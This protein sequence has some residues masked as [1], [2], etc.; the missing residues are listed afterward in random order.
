ME[1]LMNQRLLVS[2]VWGTLLVG[3]GGGSMA[4]MQTP[5]QP[6]APTEADI[7]ASPAA[8][9][10][11]EAVA[12]VGR[13]EEAVRALAEWCKRQNIAPRFETPKVGGTQVL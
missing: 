13:D 8:K 11:Q 9:L 10:L 5:Q 6:A 1:T 12:A 3:V 2:A 4:G 7:A